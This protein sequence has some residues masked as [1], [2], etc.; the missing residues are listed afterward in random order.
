MQSS[1]DT[2]RG[3]QPGNL[4]IRRGRR[5]SQEIT[6]RRVEIRRPRRPGVL[7]LIGGFVLLI[8]VGT[9]LL[10]LPIASEDRQS[11]PLMR[12][13]F[14]ATSAVCVTGLV[15]VDTRETWSLFGEIV[16]EIGRAHV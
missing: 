6:I 7:L 15:V 12:A 3:A 2:R 9:A 11:A 14:T 16:I 8:V 13:L 5:T 4:R 10:M 1:G